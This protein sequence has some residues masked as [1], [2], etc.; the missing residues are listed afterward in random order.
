ME[1]KKAISVFECILLVMASIAGAYLLGSAING[2]N[3]KSN[4]ENNFGDDES[5]VDQNYDYNDYSFA[6][7]LRIT[8]EIIFGE[9]GF[10]SAI[11]EQRFTCMRTTSGAICQEFSEISECNAVCEQDCLPTSSGSLTDCKIGI[12]FDPIE[13]TCQENSP[14]FECG[15][16]GGEWSQA[17]E[18][19][20]EC[21]QGCCVLGEQTLFVTETQ[22]SRLGAA[23]GLEEDFIINS[24]RVSCWQQSS[25]LEIG[26]CVFEAR[27]ETTCRFVTKDECIGILGDSILAFNNFH[28]NTLCS[29]P[30]IN[31]NDNTVSLC[32]PTDH[33]DCATEANKDEIYWFDSCGN[34]ENIFEGSNNFQKEQAW[35]NG[36]VKQK[37]D[38]CGVGEENIGSE[39][40]GNCNYLLGSFCRPVESDGTKPTYGENVC[41]SLNC[42]D[43]EGKERIHGESW[44]VSDAT[45]NFDPVESN[46]NEYIDTLI[47]D[48]VQKIKSKTE[49]ENSFFQGT[50][51]PVGSRFYRK[52]CVNGEIIVEPCAD[53]RQEECIENTRETSFG[54]FT[55]A[56]CRVNR[57]QDCTAQ[58]LKLDCENN[59]VRDCQWL[60]GIE[61]T[62]MGGVASGS[63]PEGATG[64]EATAAGS[65]AGLAGIGQALKEIKSGDRELG[66][67]IPRHAPGLN[68]WTEGEAAGICA[69]ANAV[70][71]VTYE[72]GLL[73]DDWEC[74][75]H[76]ECLPGGELELK[77]AQLC[78][79]MGDCG[80]KT[81][82]VGAKG[83]TKGYKI[84]E[85]NVKKDD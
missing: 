5:K 73:G 47:N 50:G 38:S 40:C 63:T 41:Q 64:E 29:K 54:P 32:E 16:N 69:Q 61:Y 18:D 9:E 1:D 67:C 65:G 76:C 20:S 60:D 21:R 14:G 48:A 84:T 55:E 25:S 52:L 27:G 43:D 68:F 22:C 82:F 59:D 58:K 12:C 4:Y 8:G 51:N 34:R 11:G 37:A 83:R 17:D 6:D 23:R 10:V 15:S 53:F 30:S 66:A 71:P 49:V 46:V 19:V 42:V 7:A 80:P 72:K 74:V 24:N 28:A 26:A 57:W 36:L 31:P 35:N 45:S 39:T 81:N 44:C 77:R 56:A 70:C 3:S 33:V 85:E 78:M 13:G 75:E 79:A 62:L 2:I